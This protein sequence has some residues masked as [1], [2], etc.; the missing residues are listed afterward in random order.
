M[1]DVDNANSKHEG[2]GINLKKDDLILPHVLGVDEVLE[3]LP[4]LKMV[5][6]ETLRLYPPIPRIDREAAAQAIFQ[7]ARQDRDA[8][9]GWCSRVAPLL[10][11]ETNADLKKLFV[12]LDREVRAHLVELSNTTLKAL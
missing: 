6:D 3:R 8:W 4:Y 2:G 10:A 5:W 12:A 9:L 7:R 1:R 11:S